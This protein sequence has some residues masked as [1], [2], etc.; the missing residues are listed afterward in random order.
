MF[1]RVRVVTLVIL[2]LVGV[3]TGIRSYKQ[4]RHLSSA[5]E[6]KSQLDTEC[7]QIGQY[8]PDFSLPDA[9]GN[10]WTLSKH[11]Q[12][13]VVLA[14]FCG[15]NR[16]MEAAKRISILQRAGKLRN[17]VAVVSLSRQGSR[18]FAVASGFC[19]TALSDPADSQAKEYKS[20]NCPR[21]WIISQ[22]GQILDSSESNLSGAQLT[23]FL[24]MCSKV[25][26]SN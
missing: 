24:K 11:R 25:A 10:S 1:L 3:L 9:N 15:C 4:S 6:T 2:L 20:L 8:A 5:S 17:M 18:E 14:F 22:S 12:H 13:K 7:L 21:L 26:A 23:S 16:C 19:G